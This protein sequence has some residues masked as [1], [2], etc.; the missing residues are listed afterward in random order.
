MTRF[1][2]VTVD[3]RRSARLRARRMATGFLDALV[4]EPV[5][6]SL[7]VPSMLGKRSPELVFR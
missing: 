1:L 4:G 3:N 6:Q 2:N 7:I 5:S